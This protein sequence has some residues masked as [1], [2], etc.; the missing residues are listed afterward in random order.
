MLEK[1]FRL[2]ENQTTVRR[3]FIAGL[4]TFL[5]MAYIIFVQPTV[6][7]QDF[8][9]NPTG[10]DFGA[11]LLATCLASALGCA[12][13]GLYAGYPIAL[14]PGM[15][16]NFFFISV[17]MALT[18]LGLP[19]PWR[20]ALGI[21][22]FAGVLFVILSFFGAR[23]A[24][25]DTLSPA[26]K[27]A[28]A[29]GIGLLIAFIGLKN[30]GIIV[31]NAVTGVSL[32]PHLFSRDIA[33]FFFGLG[34][35]TAFQAY[36]IRGAIVW[37]ILAGL[38]LA[39]IL[40]EISWS[41]KILGLPEIKQNAIFEMDL[42]NALLPACIPF[43]IVF[44]FM[45]F[46][47]T[48]GTLIA[49]AKQAGIMKNNEMPRAKQA[50]L[51][52]ALA[53]VGGACFGTSTITSY[54]ESAAGVQQGGRT[55]LTAL[56]AGG[57]FILAIFF[58]PLIGLVGQHLAITA[59]A[60]VI[61]GILMAQNIKEIDWDD[62]SESIPS[63]LIILGIPLTYSIADGIALGLLAYPAIKILCGKSKDVK[64]PMYLVA[65]LL[66]AYFLFIRPKI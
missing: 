32:T 59:P 43:I 11:I 45:D 60:L 54:I 8:T 51:A 63:F 17:I 19:H 50:L 10:L 28:I 13:M 7:S 27:N 18:A 47:D 25:I 39:L 34:V 15:G 22:F 4:T 55:G 62:L 48:T 38:L 65:L 24:V 2:S 29:V 44:L 41:G 40:G 35:T 14:A 66:I 61:V 64:W 21:V 23:Q 58:S 46:F 9:G 42:R 3:E 49:V 56:T 31:A 30:S 33:I 20:I 37:G 12:L 36:R 57:F 53:G 5:T 52:D 16:E 26:M 6:L 1:L